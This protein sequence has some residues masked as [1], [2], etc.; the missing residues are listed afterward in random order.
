MF[1]SEDFG[2]SSAFNKDDSVDDLWDHTHLDGSYETL[3][4][5]DGLGSM[6]NPY[7]PDTG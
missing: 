3:D 4:A 6:D 2:D 5:V 1:E 7:Q